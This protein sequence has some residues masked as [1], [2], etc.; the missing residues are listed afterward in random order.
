MR[1]R[2]KQNAL[3]V[4]DDGNRYTL[5][6][7]AVNNAPRI[8]HPNLVCEQADGD[9]D[10]MDG[11]THIYIPGGCQ[12]HEFIKTVVC[13]LS[14]VVDLLNDEL[15]SLSSICLSLSKLMATEGKTR[16]VVHSLVQTNHGCER[17]ISWEVTCLQSLRTPPEGIDSIGL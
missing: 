5:F 16:L 17:G 3:S 10:W 12:T 13:F 1:D 6:V 2:S 8:R 9:T 14:S 7:G 4:N 15:S 11:Y